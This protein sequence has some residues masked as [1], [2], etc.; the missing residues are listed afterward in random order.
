MPLDHA[1][2]QAKT[3][4][5]EAARQHYITQVARRE[6]EERKQ[7]ERTENFRKDM[8]IAFWFVI[9]IFAAVYAILHIDALSAWWQDKLHEVFSQIAGS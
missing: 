1:D 3:R 4:A 5:Y 8:K 7:R 2:Q 9:F 6:R